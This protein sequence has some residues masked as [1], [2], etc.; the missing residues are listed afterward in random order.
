MKASPY[1][2][3]ISA[4]AESDFDCSYAYY[5]NENPNL[6]DA[7]FRCINSSFESLTK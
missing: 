1:S 5:F 3:E 2:L 7:F 6:A 4:D